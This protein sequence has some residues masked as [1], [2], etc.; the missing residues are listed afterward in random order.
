MYEGLDQGRQS[1]LGQVAKDGQPD[2]QRE[3]SAVNH[4]ISSTVSS[5]TMADVSRATQAQ[6][7]QKTR[8]QQLKSSVNDVENKKPGSGLFRRVKAFFSSPRE[9][10]RRKG[11]QFRHGVRLPAGIP[12]PQYT[13]FMSE[14]KG[15]IAPRAAAYEADTEQRR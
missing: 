1:G 5:S 14:L 2:V 8:Q 11:G 6:K 10:G 15:V 13:A 7:P 12:V 9:S 3:G 4:T